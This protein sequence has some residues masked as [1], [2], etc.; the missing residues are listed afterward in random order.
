MRNDETAAPWWRHGH[1]WLLIAGPAGA[2]VAGAL[3]AWIAVAG[4]D[5]VVDPHYYRRGIAVSKQPA[6]ERAALPAMQG[7]N[8]AAT[9][10]KP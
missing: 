9:P 6:A 10:V 7:R 1:V 3:T 5:P 4:S 2:V 8:H